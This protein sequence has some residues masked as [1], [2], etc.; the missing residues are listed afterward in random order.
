MINQ[1]LTRIIV[2]KRQREKNEKGISN[3]D[4]PE[5]QTTLN[6]RHRTMTNTTQKTKKHLRVSEMYNAH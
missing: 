5:S 3:M 6:T 2:N 1:L 4:T